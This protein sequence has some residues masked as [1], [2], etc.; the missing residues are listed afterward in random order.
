MLALI[1]ILCVLFLEEILILKIIHIS[2]SS[3]ILTE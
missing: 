2:T 3:Q 1:K